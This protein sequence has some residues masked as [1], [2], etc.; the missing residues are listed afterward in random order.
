M[1]QKISPLT[2][3]PQGVSGNSTLSNKSHLYRYR[4]CERSP[5]CPQTEYVGTT[6]DCS[7]FTQERSDLPAGRQVD[8]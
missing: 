1:N 7:R 8:L 3:E 4:H 2:V 6:L 5:Q